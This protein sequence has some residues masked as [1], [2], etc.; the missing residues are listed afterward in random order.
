MS[1]H[2]RPRFFIIGERKCGTSSLYRY[3]VDHPDVLPGRRKEPNFFGQ[4]SPDDVAAR[5]GEY[6]A[7]FPRRSASGDVT[8]VWPELDERGVLYEEAVPFAREAGRAYL[9]GEASANTF[10]DVAP[11]LLERH[12]PDARLILMVRDPV[13]RAHS[14]H[15]M[16][17]RFQAE[18]RALPFVV[19]DFDADIR[20]ELAVVAGGGTAPCVSPGIYVDRLPR[21]LEVWGAGRL[22]VIRCEDLADR[23]GRARV[24]AELHEYLGLAPFAGAGDPD[25][26]YN[27][28]P[29]AEMSADTRRLLAEFYRPH[30]RAL[31]AL[32]GRELAWDDPTP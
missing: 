27:R 30:N 11:E 4:R 9:T 2:L 32:L 31:E 1:E 13:A 7:G 28:A 17:A 10:F 21:W 26:I 24:L 8:L 25:R 12:L 6:L 14:H 19:G 15:R 22:R 16:Y 23:A 20:A 18:G 3:L 29:P 5:F